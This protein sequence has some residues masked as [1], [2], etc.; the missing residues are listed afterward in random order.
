MGQ[1]LQE[2]SHHWRSGFFAS[3]ALLVALVFSALVL[4][5]LGHFR[6]AFF[7][8]NNEFFV[9]ELFHSLAGR[10]YYNDYVVAYG[11][12]AIEAGLPRIPT[13]LIDH[14]S[15]L[16]VPVLLPF[17]LVLPYWTA[18][19]VGYATI[20]ILGSLWGLHRML[21]AAGGI[22]TW[23]ACLLPLSLFFNPFNAPSGHN[24]LLN[25]GYPEALALPLGILLFA[26][27]L[28]RINRAIIVWSLALLQATARSIEYIASLSAHSSSRPLT[29]LGMMIKVHRPSLSNS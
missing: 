24:V 1:S 12:R 29:H 7:Q 27:V 4:I 21:R 10:P 5:S 19:P 6:Y 18:L 23:L 16:H 3:A 26:A 2:S 8:G 11:H 14:L 25:K 22:T 13:T 17:F 9:N 20:N 15:L 28:G